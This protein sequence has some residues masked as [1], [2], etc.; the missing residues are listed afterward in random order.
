MLLGTA[1][2]FAI[3]SGLFASVSFSQILPTSRG[4]GGGGEGRK[5]NFFVDL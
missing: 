4:G 3:G 5:A 1:H 2:H